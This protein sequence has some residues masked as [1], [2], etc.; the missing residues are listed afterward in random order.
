MQAIG[1]HYFL[2]PSNVFYA[3]PVSPVDYSKSSGGV[4]LESDAQ[5]AVPLS[6][7]ENIVVFLA[8]GADISPFEGLIPRPSKRIEAP[9]LFYSLSTVHSM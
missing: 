7:K 8:G 6:V 4:A 9:S 1:F 5:P 3:G 2:N